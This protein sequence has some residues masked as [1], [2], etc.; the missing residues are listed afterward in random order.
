MKKHG[1][2]KSDRKYEA[3]RRKGMS[4]ARAAR[5]TNAGSKRARRAAALPTGKVADL[6]A[7]LDLLRRQ[8]NSLLG[9]VAVDVGSRVRWLLP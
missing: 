8:V 4:K 9:I 6:D 7:P 2:V 1:N 5:I 3:L